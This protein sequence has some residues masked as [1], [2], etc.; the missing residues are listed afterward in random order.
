MDV[1]AVSKQI[2][3]AGLYVVQVYEGARAGSKAA[4]ST[5]DYV[6]DEKELDPKQAANLFEEFME[7]AAPGKY[8]AR[9]KKGA[10]AGAAEREISFVKV[11]QDGKVRISGA[12]DSEGVSRL[13]S[14]MEKRFEAQIDRLKQEQERTRLEEQIRELQQQVKDSRSWEP[15]LEKLVEFAAVRILHHMPDSGVTITSLPAGD[16]DPAIGTAPELSEEEAG[17]LD[18]RVNASL[19]ELAG[20]LGAGTANLLETLSRLQIDKLQ[21]LNQMDPATIKSLISML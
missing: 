12:G 20:K 17:Q 14:E 11:D 5:L 16:R 1:Q 21:K 3:K 6:Q 18:Q 10:K 13:M 19:S 15:K 8:V 7:D 4:F 2:E 9:L